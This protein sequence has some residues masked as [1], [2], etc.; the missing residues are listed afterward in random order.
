MSATIDLVNASGE[1]GL[2]LRR[3]FR[4]WAE[5]ALSGAGLADQHNTLS[6]RIVNAEEAA[7]LNSQYRHKDY[8]TNVLSFP[9]PAELRAAGQL[10]DLALCASV[11]KQEATA[12]HKAPLDHWAHL[13][14]HGVLHLLGYD[15]EH[16]N[17][18]SKMEALE[19]RILAGLGIKDPYQ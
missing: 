14:V 9:V 2:P 4:K 6:I 8:A 12:Q 3:Q 11:V 10:G 17:D 16:N 1:R 5:A 7:S 13:V 18:A 19:V 15:H